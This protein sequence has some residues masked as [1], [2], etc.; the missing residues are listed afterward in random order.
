VGACPEDFKAFQ[1]ALAVEY[2]YASSPARK[3]DIAMTLGMVAQAP[4]PSG[5][6]NRLALAF[7][8]EAFSQKKCGSASRLVD[9]LE[10][11]KVNSRVLIVTVYKEAVKFGDVGAAYDLGEYFLAESGADESEGRAL[12][13]EISNHRFASEWY[14]ERAARHLMGNYD[15]APLGWFNLKRRP[16]EKSHACNQIESLG[17]EKPN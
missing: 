13:A 10:A 7:A 12:M 5:E 6:A 16:G 8:L 9:V 1:F 11:L 2:A 4:D 17:K 14:K 15:L 3:I